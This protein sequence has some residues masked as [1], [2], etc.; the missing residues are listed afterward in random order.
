MNKGDETMKING[1]EIRRLAEREFYLKEEW[2]SLT[3]KETGD[4]FTFYRT[5]PGGSLLVQCEDD[6]SWWMV[7]GETLAHLMVEEIIASREKA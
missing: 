4:E 7:D 2:C 5:I 3:D 6:K 1:L